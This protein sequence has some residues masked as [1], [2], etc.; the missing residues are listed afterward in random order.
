VPLPGYQEGAAYV[1]ALSA[2]D[3]G[4]F[5]VREPTSVPRGARVDGGRTQRADDAA[6]PLPELVTDGVDGRLST[7]RRRARAPCGSGWSREGRANRGA[8]AHATARRRFDPRGVA[9]HARAF[10]RMAP[11]A[12]PGMAASWRCRQT[13]SPGRL[14]GAAGRRRLDRDGRGGADELAAFDPMRSPHAVIDLFA[15]VAATGARARRRRRRR[16]AR[17]DRRR[18]LARRAIER[19]VVDAADDGAGA[20]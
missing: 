1:D 19:I 12:L 6:A 13:S 5:L 10:D 9:A 8:R 14:R 11:L 17:R 16:L 3:A 18:E 4:L 15:L 7:K 2:C 20:N